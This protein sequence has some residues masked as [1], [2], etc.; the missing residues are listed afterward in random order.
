M[1]D[2]RGTSA[3]PSSVRYLF[4]LFS[5]FCLRIFFLCLCLFIFDTRLR[6]VDLLR[7]PSG[8]AIC[9]G[10]ALGI[11]PFPK[12][13]ARPNRNVRCTHREVV[14]IIAVVIE[15][16]VAVS[17]ERRRSTVPVAAPHRNDEQLLW[18]ASDAA[19]P[20]VQHAMRSM[21]N[22]GAP[23]RTPT[24]PWAKESLLRSKAPAKGK[25]PY[26]SAAG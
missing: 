3:I 23:F 7:V 15:V 18:R 25:D 2:E 24:R 16:V 14:A 22:G 6:F 17:P 11:A 12:S 21:A 8:N 19:L 26:P 10:R 1:I 13:P 4:S 9:T 20:N 5:F